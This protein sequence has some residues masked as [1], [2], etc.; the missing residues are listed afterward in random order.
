MTLNEIAEQLK[1]AAIEG[2]G[3]LLLDNTIIQTDSWQLVLDLINPQKLELTLDPEND[4]YVE[5]DIL[6]VKGEGPLYNSTGISEAQIQGEVEADRVCEL[7]STIDTIELSEIPDPD[8]GLIDNPNLW[9]PI[10]SFSNIS[11][12]V[13]SKT[14]TLTLNK[15]NSNQSYDILPTLKINLSKLG[16]KVTKTYAGKSTYSYTFNINGEFNVGAATIPT[17]VEL[18]AYSFSTQQ[19]TLVLGKEGDY[20][21]NLTDTFNLL[22]GVN[23]FQQMPPALTNVGDFGIIKMSILFN[24]SANATLI[25]NVLVAFG[26][27]DWEVVPSFLIK[28]A[29]VTIQVNKPF[30]PDMSIISIISGE[31]HLGSDNPYVFGISMILG[32]GSQDWIMTLSANIPLDNISAFDALP[33]GLNVTELNL[34][35]D[36]STAELKVNEFKITY[37]PTSKT[38]GYMSLDISLEAVW[39]FYYSST[40]DPL[41]GIGN[42]YLYLKIEN[43]IPTPSDKA[44]PNRIINLN[45]GG[46]I[47]IDT[48]YLL[49]SSSYS[50]AP[51]AWSFAVTQAPDSVLSL[52]NL[53]EKFLPDYNMENLPDFVPSDIKLSGFEIKVYSDPATS[54]NTYEFRGETIIDWDVT[55]GTIPVSAKASFDVKYKSTGEVE[56]KLS[57]ST[58]IS[59]LDVSVGYEFKDTEKCLFVDWNAFKGSYCTTDQGG[60]YVKIAMNDISFGGILEMLVL[61]VQ[62]SLTSYSLPAPWN[63]LN[64]ISLKGLT[65][66][67]DVSKSPYDVEVTYSLPKPINLGFLKID[68]LN[69]K[70]P[71]PSK[72][73]TSYVNIELSGSYLGGKPIPEWKSPQEQPPAVPGEGN[74]YFDLRLLAL[75]QRVSIDGYEDLKTIKE[76]I[77]AMRD[78]PSTGGQSN[79]VDGQSQKGYPVFNNDSN[80]LIATNF[81]ILK[82]GNDYTVDMSV[83]FNDPELYG[84]RIEMA[85]A[86]AKV[87]NGLKF[88]IMYKKVSDSV[89]VYQ[90]EL[91]LP[92]IMRY[93][94]FGVVS[95]ILPVIVIQIYTNGDFYFDIG[96]P[97]NEDFSRSFTATVIVVGIPFRGSAGFYFGKLSNETATQIP[98]TTKGTFNPVIIFGLGLQVGIGYDLQYGILKAGFSLTLVGIIEGV[99]AAFSPYDP[100]NDALADADKNQVAGS[101]YY[102]VSGTFGIIGK[103]YGAIDF[104]IIKAD[105]TVNIYALVKGTFEAYR[106]MLLAI[107]IGVEAKA[108]VKINLGLFSIKISFKFSM[109]IEQEYT[110]GSNNEIDA[111]WYSG[112]TTEVLLQG[113]TNGQISNRSRLRSPRRN[114]LHRQVLRKELRRQI[115][116]DRKNTVRVYQRLAS[117]TPW[118]GMV[119]RM[120]ENIDREFNWTPFTVDAKDPIAMWLMPGLTV[121]GPETGS[122]SEQNANYIATL[123][124][125]APSDDIDAPKS[126]FSYLSE[127][128]FRWVINSWINEDPGAIERTELDKEAISLDDLQDI[129][130]ALTETTDIDPI[131]YADIKVFLEQLFKINISVGEDEQI[132][133]ALFAMIPEFK[134]KVPA[135]NE[136]PIIERDFYTY[137]ECSQKYQDELRLYFNQLEVQVQEETGN[138]EVEANLKVEE[139]VPSSLATFIFE[140]YFLL[141]AKQLLQDALDAMNAFVY[142][143]TE[144]DSLDSILTW[145]NSIGTG[146]LNNNVTISELIETTRTHP[147]AHTEDSAS[148]LIT[149]VQYGIKENQSLLDIAY[150]SAMNFSYLSVINAD[151]PNILMPDAQIELDD[152]IYIVSE[153][154]TLNTAAEFFEM[155]VPEMVTAN[156]N[157]VGKDTSLL[158]ENAWMLMAA[159]D[160]QVVTNDS[161]ESISTK[162]DVDGVTLVEQNQNVTALLVP[163]SIISFEETEY[164]VEST[165]TFY[166]IATKLNT[167]VAVLG[168]DS[169]LQ[170]Q[171]GLL[172]PLAMVMIPPI[173]YEV[174]SGDTIQ[175]IADVY[176]ITAESLG[177]NF[178]NIAITNI[179]DSSENKTLDLPPL[180]YLEVE[181]ILN[182]LIRGGKIMSLAGMSSRYALHG[183]QLPITE[184]I[185]FPTGAPCEEGSNCGVYKMTGQQWK[186][187]NKFTDDTYSFDIIKPEEFSWITFNDTEEDTLN[188]KLGEDSII[189]I[190]DVLGSAQENGV[191]PDVVSLD[192]MPFAEEN[193]GNYAFKSYME[194]QS[195]SPITLPYGSL[196]DQTNATPLIWN[197]PSNLESLLSL[198]KTLSPKFSIQIGRSEEGSAKMEKRSASYYS[199]GTLVPVQIKKLARQASDDGAFLNYELLGTN[200]VSIAQLEELLIVLRPEDDLIDQIQILYPPNATADNSE[201][202]QSDGLENLISFIT[203][204]NLSTDT[205]PPTSNSFVMKSEAE[206]QELSH[207]ILNDPYDF[208]RLLWQASITRNGGYS[209]Y[210]E[211]VESQTGFSDEIFNEDDVATLYLLIAYSNPSKENQKNLLTPYMNCAITG[212]TIDRAKETVFAESEEQLSSHTVKVSK[213]LSDN[214]VDKSE[215]L[216]EIAEKYYS[217]SIE[218]AQ[219]NSTIEL[220]LDADPSTSLTISNIIYELRPDENSPGNNLQDILDYFGTNETALQKANPNVDLNQLSIW[221]VLNIPTVTYELVTGG[222]AGTQL[223]QIAKHYFIPLDLLAYENR[224]LTGLFTVD[225]VLEINNQILIKTAT[226][227]QG[228]L[229]FTMYV[230]DP[231]DQEEVF[232]SVSKKLDVTKLAESNNADIYLRN[233]YTL[234]SYQV[235]GNV[236]FNQSIMGLPVGP[237]ED[238]ESEEPTDIFKYTKVVPI[239][240]YSKYNSIVNKTGLPEA[241]ENPYAGIGGIGQIHLDWR[242]LY[243]NVT[244][245]PLSNPNLNTNM[246]LNNPPAPIGY[247]DMLLG[248]SQWPSVMTDYLF[249]KT[250][251]AEYPKLLLNFYFDP[252]RYEEEESGNTDRLVDTELSKGQQNAKDDLKTY[253]L[254]YYQLNQKDSSD[255]YFLKA[256]LKNTLN[257][258][259]EEELSNAQFEQI[260]GFVDDIYQY[261]VQVSQAITPDTVSGFSLEQSINPNEDIPSG[262]LLKLE[263][264]LTFERPIDLIDT[265]FKEQ[266]EVIRSLN[267]INPK[268]ELKEE[269]EEE[270]QET[271]DMNLFAYKFEEAFLSPDNYI[272]KV[273]TSTKLTTSNDLSNNKEIWVVRMGLKTGESIFY[274]IG[275]TPYFYAPRPLARVLKTQKV[276]I[277]SYE[278]GIGINYDSSQ[279]KT[280]SGID[281]DSWGSIAL[282]A[283]DNFL[284]PEYASPAFIIDQLSDGNYLSQILDAKDSLAKAISNDVTNILETPIPTSKNLENAIERYKQ[285]LLV[286]LSNAYQVTALVQYDVDTMANYTGEIDQLNAPRLFGSP[287]ASIVGS[288]IPLNQEFSLSN[289]KIALPDQKVDTNANLSFFFT[290][291]YPKARKNILLDITWN[292]S[293]LEH[294]IHNVAEIDGYE[295]SDW[296][297]FLL[298]DTKDD[299]YTSPLRKEMGEVEIP[300]ILRSYPTPPSLNSQDYQATDSDSDSEITVKEASL[301]NYTYQYSTDHA[302]QDKINNQVRFNIMGNVFYSSAFVKTLDLFEELAQFTSV[303]PSIQKDFI[304]SLSKINGKTTINDDEYRIALAAV[305]SFSEICNLVA[306][307]WS[308]WRGANSDN[309][310]KMASETSSDYIFTISEEP[311]SATDNELRLTVELPNESTVKNYT[312][313]S[314]S[315]LPALLNDTEAFKLPLVE[316]ENYK[317]ELITGTTT[318]RYE[319]IENPGEY[320]DFDTSQNIPERQLLVEELSI[321]NYQNSWS[322]VAITRN[323]NLMSDDTIETNL[324]FIYQTPQIK[325]AN[326]LIPLLDNNKSIDIAKIP[327]NSVQKRSLSE[328]L[329]SFFKDLLED[330]LLDDQAIKIE[331]TYS[332]KLADNTALSSIVLPVLLLPITTIPL[333]DAYEP[334]GGSCPKDYTSDSAFVC[335]LATAIEQWFDRNKPSID[336]AKFHFDVALFSGLN[337]TQLPLIRLRKVYL[338]EKNILR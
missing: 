78:I 74:S 186:L 296:L 58:T 24:Q 235:V 291:R 33:G 157:Q 215:S 237:T 249:E 303:Y 247:T 194:W 159:C 333:P 120:V 25:D 289:A 150:D 129:F 290:T 178:H 168:A 70:K 208:V 44:N 8:M 273:A 134:L 334:E 298:P 295:A 73:E 287:S 153:G 83:V 328:H 260:L 284:S 131:S 49:V 233:L 313:L 87:F 270:D 338:E 327:E 46:S 18:P 248:V 3:K 225:S 26:C 104:G 214:D 130:D 311:V 176:S 254:L 35:E 152:K 99:I 221:E 204:S 337:E 330:S 158:E 138:D 281:M 81:G 91:T 163:G 7:T 66:K 59:Q 121:S 127:N 133:G 213:N 271:L 94:Q 147:L 302:A 220:N 331:V 90:I 174:Q 56:G 65:L 180:E 173:N 148:I 167:T 272:L 201:G 51:T 19:W 218:L 251:S 196:G 182:E 57:M 309:S 230:N 68:A 326:K 206:D 30:Q 43:P 109:T 275:S 75:G 101:Y 62:P 306:E 228:N 11:L 212:E 297:T 231:G 160:Y 45:A 285:N 307:A 335:K 37:N 67:I 312:R 16:F 103:L 211:L 292:A 156:D 106:Q 61:V 245:T 179:F 128:I 232:D 188:V 256:Y 108:S 299:T 17:S 304:E 268:T 319:S 301:W 177:N 336:Q 21:V 324:D 48:T 22:G 323:E 132:E 38:M 71:D 207:G 151:N 276:N 69:F 29:A 15:E 10:Y 136:D 219:H 238:T 42:P 241:S 321:L 31:F 184:D 36:V 55:I 222:V 2:G 191:Q 64:E 172:E 227:P 274:E 181:N 262:D 305:K 84:L 261:L 236:N 189:L 27:N 141:I 325:F 315:K 283:I 97:H 259:E 162:Y 269:G 195:A 217:N 115:S 224:F 89:G 105:V 223:D 257:I 288:T 161:L 165:D 76:V 102:K 20:L 98:E 79:P 317:A 266:S 226:I 310:A 155:T 72:G 314:S 300:I 170:S 239:N 265:S 125:D 280:F 23:A 192:I 293:H 282:G 320:L 146:N 92:D 28:E 193:A 253:K 205:N 175:S 32:T 255:N 123:Y 124:T 142:T 286:A 137:S 166:T 41:L 197:F 119:N 216:S 203:Q 308:V 144:G 209:L 14:A 171:T 12:S 258:N 143:L 250:E 117:N 85:G 264:G 198:G 187:P 13:S 122:L 202:V 1:A 279:T 183:L 234:L 111:P 252:S 4:I 63:L 316:I 100:P 114:S 9:V 5:D 263:V 80:W 332:Y 139:E 126:S 322:A 140:D 95:I 240:T 82:V 135:Y 243:G 107:S 53:V 244:Q 242:D 277:Y 199:W 149:G 246:P 54:T 294:N 210:Y 113:R 60:K 185:T 34:P 88:E 96:F 39:Y 190:E 116:L 154:N 329:I 112:S 169:A 118:K 6:F 318:Y 77:A 278:P 200:E 40:G 229:G 145:I 93:L 110:L 267:S 50:N 164:E 86:K 47:Y 52:A